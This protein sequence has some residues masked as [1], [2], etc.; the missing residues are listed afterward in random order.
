MYVYL[1]CGRR[2]FRTSHREWYHGPY[3]SSLGARSKRYRFTPKRVP[4]CSRIA[5]AISSS[6]HKLQWR[7]WFASR[8]E[9]A[10]GS[11]AFPKQFRF[12]RKVR[13]FHLEQKDQEFSQLLQDFMSDM[14]FSGGKAISRARRRNDS[15]FS[16]ILYIE[17]VAHEWLR[18]SCF[19]AISSDKNG[20]Y[21]LVLNTELLQFSGR[22]LQAAG[23]HRTQRT[24]R[25]GLTRSGPNTSAFVAKWRNL[26]IGYRCRFLLLASRVDSA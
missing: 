8:G 25:C 15:S 4:D 19:T 18:R 20:G 13:P 24:N 14:L 23:T 3:C 21:V 5:E 16:N 2:Q 17:R 1:I 26:M 22:C 9:D 11:R 10:S 7:H 12:R 6:I